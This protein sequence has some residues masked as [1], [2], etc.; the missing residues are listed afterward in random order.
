M[1]PIEAK[2]FLYNYIAI[3]NSFVSELVMILLIIWRSENKIYY[4]NK[5]SD[6]ETYVKDDLVP[7][8]F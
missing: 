2:Y 4:F 5:C 7:E 3:Y 1:I 8:S 6:Y